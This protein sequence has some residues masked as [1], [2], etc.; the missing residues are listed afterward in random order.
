MY[1]C[2]LAQYLEY[3][4]K[5][6]KFLFICAVFMYLIV[7]WNL[8][9]EAMFVSFWGSGFLKTK[10]P[11]KATKILQCKFLLCCF[12]FFLFIPYR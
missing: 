12:F 4:C 1:M 3:F 9:L 5:M 11:L 7:F 10:R 2:V 6:A 8:L